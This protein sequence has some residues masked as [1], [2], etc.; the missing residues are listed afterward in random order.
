MGKCL[1]RIFLSDKGVTDLPVEWW[2]WDTA[3]KRVVKLVEQGK[4]SD[5]YNSIVQELGS[6][7]QH[8]FIKKQQAISFETDK[9]HLD[10]KN[11]VIQMDFS[12]NYTCQWQNEVQSAH[13]HQTQV[14]VFTVAI[15]TKPN[16]PPQSHIYVSDNLDHDKQSIAVF[17]DM[18]LSDLKSKSPEIDEVSFWTDG[19]SS[20]FKNRYIVSLINFLKLRHTL[21]K[22]H[23][24]YFA[25]SH[26]KGPVDGIGGSAKR[27]V[28]M[29]VLTQNA[30][31]KNAATFA[32]TAKNVC[33][34]IITY[35]VPSDLIKAHGDK[36]AIGQLWEKALPIHGIKETHYVLVESNVT[37]IITKRFSRAK[38]YTIA[39]AL[40]ACSNGHNTS[41]HN[42][43]R[44]TPVAAS[45][46]TSTSTAST[47]PSTTETPKLHVGEYIAAIYDK[48]WF[49]AQVVDDKEDV[50]IVKWLEQV[51]NGKFR[52]PVREEIT[53]LNKNLVLMKVQEPDW[54]LRYGEIPSNTVQE[55]MEVFQRREE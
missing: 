45:I 29:A 37:Q 20:Q 36:M 23:W 51:G 25:T 26:G 17:V 34:N 32:A 27:C 41:T 24:N 49:L 6:F 14:T 30:V 47:G 22:M 8:C 33:P 55:I 18:L 11:A 46:L 44:Q 39:N 43:S 5:L 48:S 31:V 21:T 12:E 10:G 16:K 3:D 54:R 2:K 1:L 35:F 53:L 13:W 9:I 7:V 50:L 52:W 19:P 40:A 42:E 28:W 4:V 38:K 15:W